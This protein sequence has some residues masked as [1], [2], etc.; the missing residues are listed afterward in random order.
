MAHDIQAIVA[1][2]DS[3]EAQLQ[4]LGLWGGSAKQPSVQALS[5]NS[6][7]CLD[8]LEFHEWLEYVLIAR[9]KSMIASGQPLPENM[10]IHT[11]AQEKYRGQWSTYRSLIGLL[12]ELDDLITIKP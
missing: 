5:S 1:K 9:L 2:L 7:F 8:T 3:L 11:Y 4:E 10:M 12:K 6:P